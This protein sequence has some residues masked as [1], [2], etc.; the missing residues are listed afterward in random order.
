MLLSA[1]IQESTETIMAASEQ[2][3]EA[4][5]PTSDGLGIAS[6]GYQQ[7]TSWQVSIPSHTHRHSSLEWNAQN[8][9]VQAWSTGAV[10]PQSS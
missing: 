3:L 4:E 2:V 6:K 5:D 9:N 1:W 10:L 7:I 8:G